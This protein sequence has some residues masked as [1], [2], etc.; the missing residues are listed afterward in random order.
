ML[1]AD[2][3]E[4]LAL[5]EGS[6]LTAIRTGAVSGAATDLLAHK[7]A[8]NVAI[9]GSGVQARTQLEAICTVR[10]IE[11]VWVFSPTHQHADE[12]AAQMAGQ[13]PI[14]YDVKVA[15]TARD[16][17]VQ[18]D[19]ICTATNSFTPVFNGRDLRP[20][21]HVNS[22]G[23]YTPD[24]QEVDTKTIQ[25]S[26]VIVDSRESVMAEA[27][28]LIIPLHQGLISHNH[29]HAEIGEILTGTKS[30]RT[31][32]D[33]ITYFKSCGVAVQD[34]AA[35]HLALV[36]AEHLNLGTEAFL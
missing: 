5:M 18:A 17:A 31:S 26:L 36:Q 29:I 32:D 20:G 25:R 9:F 30:G 3:G 11:S 33:Q 10:A 15:E 14:P 34:A 2:T 16:A 8:R 27:G 23:S 21:V 19:I 13:G 6:T 35:G 12:F 28:D 24:M 7:D 1:D 4:P 22:I